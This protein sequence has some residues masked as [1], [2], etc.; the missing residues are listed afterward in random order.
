MG[1][2]ELKQHEQ[3]LLDMFEGDRQINCY[4]SHNH[5]ARTGSAFVR[6]N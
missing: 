4:R 1:I 6:L 3:G 2:N 5:K